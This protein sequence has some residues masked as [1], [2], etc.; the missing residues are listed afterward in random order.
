MDEPDVVTSILE[1]AA[2][3]VELSLFLNAVTCDASNLG[4]ELHNVSRGITLFS[5]TLKQLAGVLKHPYS[6]HSDEAV[7][8][9][10]RISEYSKAVFDEVREMLNR[11]CTRKKDG[12]LGPSFQERFKFVF[13]KHKVGYLL[14][15]LESL[16]LNLALMLQIQQLGQSQASTS[17]RLVREVRFRRQSELT[18][19]SDKP[20]VVAEKMTEIQRER[21]ETQN[22][23][24]VRYRQLSLLD[25]LYRAAGKEAQ[26][27]KEEGT[28]LLVDGNADASPVTMTNGNPQLALEV[29]PESPTTLIK[30]PVYTLGELDQS[31]QEIQESPREMLQASNNVIDPLLEHWTN[32]HEIR[33]R[34]HRRN[35]R[36]TPSVSTQAEDDEDRPLHRKFGDREESPR[37]KLLEG[38]TTDWRQPHSAEA[39][40]EKARLQRHYSKYQPSVSADSS[41]VELSGGSKG[42]KK[43]S[44]RHH[45][46]DSGSE[47]SEP[48][49]PPPP[50]PPSSRRRNSDC[51]TTDKRPPLS[52]PMTHA[53]T[54]GPA[55]SK[56][57]MP[58]QGPVPPPNQRPGVPPPGPYAPSGP[59][60]HRP[61]ASPI[62]TPHHSPHHSGSS[63]LQPIHTGNAPNPYAP[64][65]MT[66]YPPTSPVTAYPPT[67]PYSP[68]STQYPGFGPHYVP[69]QRYMPPANR[70]PVPRPVSSDGK[71][72]SPSRHP[73][74]ASYGSRPHQKT[75]EEKRASREKTKKNLRE[76]ATK[77]LLSAGTIAAFVEALEGLDI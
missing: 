59:P 51:P 39:R 71:Q 55:Q 37:H 64:A 16:K 56:R 52:A 15:Q 20:E 69:N 57:A 74:A 27:A 67:S 8:A 19:Y 30:L 46:L 72:K 66:T 29:A 23:V 76:G 25:E 70:M 9:A 10:K 22:V 31:L 54:F 68:S 33:E 2:A 7:E 24:I 28:K 11:C 42:S 40:R 49:P 58:F 73:P 6:V 21:L 38:P 43:N 62:Q 75:G 50:P 1:V 17:K 65:P 26:E 36:F 5:L 34:R 18:R 13:R 35:H 63:P 14:G 4:V 41:D 53:A 48:E 45:I 32:W 61:Y 44:P 3:G 77:G 47:T 60:A 12:S